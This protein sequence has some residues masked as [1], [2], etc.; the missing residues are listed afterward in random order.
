MALDIE[1]ATKIPPKV[2]TIRVR[3][4]NPE[5]KK[6]WWQEYKVETRKG[7]TMLDAL[8]AIK[9]NIDH[10]LTVRYSCRMGLCG[11][12]G[13]NINGTP[14]LACQTQISQV[15]TNANPVI[16]VEPLSNFPVVKDLM[17]D[18]KDFFEK[19]RSVKPYLIR[20]DID[21][22]EKPKGQ[23]K[24]TPEEFVD[25]FQ[26]SNCIYC[27]LCYASCPVVAADPEYLGPQALM[28]AF[29]FIN[30]A[31]DEG[32]QERFAIIDTEH[33]CHKCHFAAT[34]S[35]VCPKAVDPAGA[36][37]ALRSKLYKYRFGFFKKKAS[38]PLPPPPEKGERISLP[39]EATT[40]P[41]VDLKAMEKE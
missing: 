4:Y 37:Q 35:A 13:V 39:P 25:I 16:T 1:A 6:I 31:R 22:Q 34:C 32:H 10:T 20:K 17:T 28:Y 29:R 3:R 27:G 21:E 15:A 12:C 7:M 41:G 19:H 24:M 33:G 26:F 5:S 11:S 9:E 30:D 38:K 14:M 40:L 18:F 8:L 23:L 36:I 2:V